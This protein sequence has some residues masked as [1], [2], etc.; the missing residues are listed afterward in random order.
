MRRTFT[1]MILLLFPASLL[2]QQSLSGEVTDDVTFNA[3]A[4]VSLINL[5]TGKTV[6]TANNGTFSIAGRPGDTLRFSM[7]GYL[8]QQVVI[9][10]ELFSLPSLPIHMKQGVI[11]L[12]QQLVRGR[13]H[14]AD[15]LRLRNEYAAW[16]KKQQDW[17][18]NLMLPPYRKQELRDQ[19]HTV[20]QA[21][22]I[23]QL[24]KNLSFRKNR[25]REAFRKKLLAKEMEDYLNYAYDPAVVQKVT[26]LGGDSLDYFMA[27]YR[28]GPAIL[29]SSNAYE[30]MGYIKQLYQHYRDSISG[31]QAT[32]H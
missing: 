28:P 23:N 2:A 7:L 9:S 30:L 8:P 22:N 3:L 25:Q 31:V 29:G 11:T 20:R 13:N 16:F 14:H 17:D 32:T 15:S 27:H 1:S 4:G 6:I 10:K 24:Y 12:Q 19:L 26:G 21:L 18:F 5:S